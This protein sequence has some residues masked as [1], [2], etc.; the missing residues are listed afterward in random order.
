MAKSK[1]SRA[2]PRVPLATVRTSIDFRGFLPT[3]LLRGSGGAEADVI[4]CS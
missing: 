3:V 1:Y 4:G 2:E